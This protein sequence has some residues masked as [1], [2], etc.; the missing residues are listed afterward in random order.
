V[1]APSETKKAKAPARFNT[2]PYL[3]LITD[4]RRLGG[5]IRMVPRPRLSVPKNPE[6]KPQ[7][8]TGMIHRAARFATEYE[9][10]KFLRKLDRLSRY[11]YTVST[12]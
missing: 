4:R 11:C 12:L 2:G 10:R 6:T 3:I 8:T 9:A 1:S 5:E 7:R